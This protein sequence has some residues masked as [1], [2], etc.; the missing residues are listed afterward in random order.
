MNNALLLIALLA[1]VLAVAVAADTTVPMEPLYPE[2]Y[3]DGEEERDLRFSARSRSVGMETAGG[4]E[5]AQVQYRAQQQQLR[6]SP[7][8]ARSRGAE[9][10]DYLRAASSFEGGDEEARRASDVDGNDGRNMFGIPLPP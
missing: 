8:E 4:L 9:E 1:A 3:H 7:M 10:M 6:A 2:N 5:P